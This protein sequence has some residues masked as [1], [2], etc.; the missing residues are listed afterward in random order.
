MKYEVRF[1]RD[2]ERDLFEL[3]RYFALSDA[4]EYAETLLRE[5][6]ETYLSLE[7]TPEQCNMSCYNDRLCIFISFFSMFFFKNNIQFLHILN[8][9]NSFFN[10]F[11]EGYI[12]NFGNAGH[13]A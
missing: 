3:Y 5:L 11:Q 10:S 12:L 1:I 6:E 9:R 8:R 7:T 2:A 4:P 13:K